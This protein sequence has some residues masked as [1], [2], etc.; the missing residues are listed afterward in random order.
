VAGL[1][2]T[3]GEPNFSVSIRGGGTPFI[4][5]DDVPVSIESLSTLSVHD[6]ERIEV[7]KGADAAIFGGRGGNGV[8]G[9]YTRRGAG[10]IASEGMLTLAAMGLQIEREFY[11]PDYD[12]EKPEHI[13]PDKRTTLYW[14]P[15]IR[16]DSAGRASVSFYNHD[17]ETTVTG[18]AEG[19]SST[20]KSGATT[21]KYAITKN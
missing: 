15:L 16:T 6:V 8:I 4:L 13:K 14:A 2:I 7:W 18:V 19:I 5:I 9:F 21:F 10:S 3:G 17:L 12:A 11:S 20:G 1:Q